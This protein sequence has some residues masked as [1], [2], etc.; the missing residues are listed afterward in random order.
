MEKAEFFFL[1]IVISY[2]IV[3]NC[4]CGMHSLVYRFQW[5]KGKGGGLGLLYPK[6]RVGVTVSESEGGL[7]YPKLMEGYGI[8]RRGLG[9]R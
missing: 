7:R 8:R 1:C 3:C 9:L 4:N 5:G 2:E 6:E